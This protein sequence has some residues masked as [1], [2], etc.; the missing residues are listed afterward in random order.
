MCAVWGGP[1]IHFQSDHTIISE[2]LS[3]VGAPP[4][5]SFTPMGF[6]ER[7]VPCWDLPHFPVPLSHTGFRVAL[8]LVGQ[9]VR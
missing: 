5:P 6:V 3:E 1:I 9:Q 7:T 4:P 8:V 2:D